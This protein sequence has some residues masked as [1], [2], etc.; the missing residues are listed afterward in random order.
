MDTGTVLEIAQCIIDNCP[1]PAMDEIAGQSFWECY[2][3]ETY[4]EIKKNSWPDE[5]T[6]LE[7]SAILS[8][9]WKIL[10][11]N[12][13]Q[14]YEW[15]S[16]LNDISEDPLFGEVL[17]DAFEQLPVGAIERAGQAMAE[18]GW[19]RF[20]ECGHWPK[21]TED[22]VVNRWI[23]GYYIEDEWFEFDPCYERSR[24]DWM[25]L[26]MHEI[27]LY[28]KEKIITKVGHEIFLVNAP[29]I[30]PVEG[31][32]RRVTRE[33]WMDERQVALEELENLLS[34]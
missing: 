31:E 1:D 24:E 2:G 8:M 34:D 14:Y 32:F 11:G 28:G 19:H 17:L 29:R 16:I 3:E 15:Y 7:L 20:L 13:G 27:E 26:L 12:F 22:V 30:Q 10:D 33:E 6:G 21:R 4:R 9:L 18:D 25:E 5:L 23:I